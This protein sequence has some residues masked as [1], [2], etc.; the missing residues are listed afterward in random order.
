M[1]NLL[2]DLKKLLKYKKSK[3]FYAAKLRVSVL[4]VEE[5]LKELRQ[6]TGT[7]KTATLSTSNISST[8][9]VNKDKGSKITEEELDHKTGNKRVV[10]QS[11]KPLNPKEI[12]QLVGADNITTFVDRSWLKSQRDGTWTY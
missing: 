1:D 9:T 11:D 8:W 6:S 5:L 3:H 2:E 7:V 10:I 4:K 12:E